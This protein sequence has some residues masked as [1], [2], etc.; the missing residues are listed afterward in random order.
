MNYAAADGGGKLQC[1]IDRD[2]WKERI[3]KV[4]SL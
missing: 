2:R 1:K 3:H 4:I